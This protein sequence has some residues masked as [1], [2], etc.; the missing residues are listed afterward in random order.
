MRAVFVLGFALTLAFVAC[1]SGD[2]NDGSTTYAEDAFEVWVRDLPE[3]EDGD[4]D[5]YAD[6]IYEHADAWDDLDAPNDISDEQDAWVKAQRSAGDVFRSIDEQ[7]SPDSDEGQ[8]VRHLREAF[9]AWADAFSG[10]YR[11]RFYKMSAASMEPSFSDGDA[12]KVP[13]YEGAP[14]K[15]GEIAVFEFHL[16]PDRDLFKRVIGIPG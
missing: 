1:S 11:V 7:V 13:V 16:D 9:D 10:R 2:D 5:A 6:A 3:I 12:M 14:I 4:F 8:K 15:R